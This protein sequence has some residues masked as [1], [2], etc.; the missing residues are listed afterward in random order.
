MTI[1]I[2]GGTVVIADGHARR[3][4]CS[5]DGETDR[6]RA[7][8]GRPSLGADLADV[9]D[10]VIDATGKYVHPR[11]HRR[12]TPT[13]S[14]R[15]A[16]PSRP[17]PSRPARAPRPGAARRRSSTSRCSARASACRTAW[18]RGTRRPTATAPSTTASTRS[19]AASTTTSL[20]AMDELRRRG[21]HQLQAV[22]GLPG[23]LLLRRRPDP[24]G[25]AD[26]GRQRRDDHDA[27]R[28]RHRHR[29]AGRPGARRGARPTRGTTAL[30][31]PVGDWRRRPPTARSCSPS[32]TGAPL[33]I[34]HMSRQAGGRGR[35]AAPATRAERL[36][37]DLPAVPVPVPR[38]PARRSR[39]S[40]AP[41]GS[42]RRRCAPRPRATR[43]SCGAACAPTTC[44]SSAP[45]T[46]RSASRSRRSWASATSRRSPTASARSSTAWT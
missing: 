24:A 38:G 33:Y 17:T 32:V 7:R 19:S 12:A 25:D 28:E 26:G 3:P 6:R 44:R 22:H 43:T 37:R 13:W 15:S 4:T 5:V 9:A 41:S 34:V 21:R 23:R 39:A 35:R 2:T 29:R 10:R 8:P 18:P 40:R 42:A 16:A 27:R 11:R 1:L 31:R 30:T 14:C 20:K 46:A 36:R 45:T